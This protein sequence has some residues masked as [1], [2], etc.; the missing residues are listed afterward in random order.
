MSKITRT[1]FEWNS[2]AYESKI[3][4][5]ESKNTL[6]Q[7]GLIIEIVDAEKGE[8]NFT[9]ENGTPWRIDFHDNHVSG[10]W[11]NRSNSFKVE[12]IEIIGSD[13]YSVTPVIN[14]NFRDLN[15]RIKNVSDMRKHPLSDVLY[16]ICSDYFVIMI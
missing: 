8:I 16:I 5:G 15:D 14:R 7:L 11:Y 1:Y 6:L 2:T 10:L 13:Y 9:G 12:D 4:L 3:Q